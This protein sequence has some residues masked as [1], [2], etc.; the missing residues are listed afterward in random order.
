MNCCSWPLPPAT[1]AVNFHYVNSGKQPWHNQT[2]VCS[3][4][5][6]TTHPASRYRGELYNLGFVAMFCGVSVVR[7]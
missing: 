1:T 3:G 4:I 6:T 7:S 2:F 5:L